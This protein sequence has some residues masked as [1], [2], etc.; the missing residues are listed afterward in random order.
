MDRMRI[1]E[2]L[3]IV[4]KG[5]RFGGIVTDCFRQPMYDYFIAVGEDDWWMVYSEIEITGYMNFMRILGKFLFLPIYG[6]FRRVFTD[7]R[8]HDGVLEGGQYQ[9]DV[10]S[11]H[12]GI[13][14]RVAGVASVSFQL[15]SSVN[16]C[17]QLT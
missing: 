13:K 6:D 16:V 12:E 1:G 5:R 7:T 3:G 2:F 9:A 10:S 4:F 11:W 14:G 8:I 17:V 15:L